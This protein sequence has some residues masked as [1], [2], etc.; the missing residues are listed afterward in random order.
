MELQEV[1]QRRQSCRKYADRP[2]ER[3][4]LLACVEA[5][6]IAPSGCNSQRWM[7]IVVDDAQKRTRIADALIDEEIRV[8]TFAHSIPAFIVIL[9]TPPHTP[10][11]AKQTHIL[12][13]EDT[14]VLD[15]GMAAAQICLK[16]TDLGLGS[17]VMGWCRREQVREALGIPD[18]YEIPI[19]IGLGYPLTDEIREKSRYPMETVLR[20]NGFSPGADA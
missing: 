3:E 5:G 12:S 7:F 18:E 6:R 9:S 16:A 13:H 10:L 8:N 2:V 17:L 11:N 14:R 19:I 1:L 4:K 15:I 20:L